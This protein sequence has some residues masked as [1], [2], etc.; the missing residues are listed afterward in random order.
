MNWTPVY[1][2]TCIAMVWS[3]AAAGIAYIFK[4]NVLAAGLGMF[5]VSFGVVL[6]AMSLCNA[7]ARGNH[8]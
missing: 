7:A 3:V 5:L 4:G 2:S 1:I 6:L 8:D